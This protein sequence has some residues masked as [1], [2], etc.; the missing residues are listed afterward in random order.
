MISASLLRASGLDISIFRSNVLV[1]IVSSFLWLIALLT[2][3]IHEKSCLAI[4]F[5][6]FGYSLYRL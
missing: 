5:C 3:I 2:F 6:Q 4:I 1:A